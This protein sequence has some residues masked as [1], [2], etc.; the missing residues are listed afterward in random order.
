MHKNCCL[1][2]VCILCVCECVCECV[3]VCMCTCV[4]GV[5]ECVY[6]CMCCGVCVSVCMCTCA[7]G[8]C[9]CVE[10]VSVWSMC[11]CLCV[12]VYMCG[13]CVWVW[14]HAHFDV[15]GTNAVHLGVSLEISFKTLVHCMLTKDLTLSPPYLYI[16]VSV[17]CFV[18]KNCCLDFVCILCVCECVCECVCVCMCTCVCG[19]CECVYMCMCCGVCVSVCMCTCACG[20]CECVEYVSVWSMCECLCVVVYMCGVCVWVW[21]HAHFDVYGTNAVH[22]GVSLEISFKTLVHCMLTKDLTLSPPY[23][24]IKVSGGGG[25]FPSPLTR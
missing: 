18:H 22:L 5:C 20:V 2:F 25:I 4:C 3:C 8:V 23:L 6:M 15:Y 17:T 10:Y 21:M 14:M 11:E 12:V 1:D 13:V 19:V 7:C 16:K 9:E 24:Y